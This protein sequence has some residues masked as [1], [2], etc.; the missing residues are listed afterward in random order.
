MK[1]STWHERALIRL[2]I[3]AWLKV[4]CSEMDELSKSSLP[5]YCGENIELAK[6]KATIH[7]TVDVS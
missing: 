3:D 5:I 2:P 7:E 6:N 4:I 1:R